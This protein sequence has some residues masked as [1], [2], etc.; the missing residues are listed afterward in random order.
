MGDLETYWSWNASQGCYVP[1]FAA[2]WSYN[3]SHATWSAYWWDAGATSWVDYTDHLTVTESSVVTETHKFKLEIADTSSASLYRVEFYDDREDATVF[4]NSCDLFFNS[5]ELG[6][7]PYNV[8][9]D[10][11]DMN[12][13][14]SGVSPPTVSMSFEYL[15][16]PA[17]ALKVYLDF[18]GTD[19]TVT[20]DPYY[21]IQNGNNSV[22]LGSNG[23]K[24]FCC[25]SCGNLHVVYNEIRDK[26]NVNYEVSYDGGKTWNLTYL[27]S[28]A[29]YDQ[30]YPKISV[31]SHGNI[32]VVFYGIDPLVHAT[33]TQIR[34][35]RYDATTKSWGA[36]TTITSDT[37]FGSYNPSI[38][39]DHDNI[40]HVVYYRSFKIYYI[41]FD[42]YYWST[43]LMLCGP[44]MSERPSIE[45][46]K[47]NFLNVVWAGYS[48]P[49]EPYYHIH[50]VYSSNHGSSFSSPTV[51]HLESTYVQD[52][53]VVAVDSLG[54]VHVLW[55]G[56]SAAYNA[57][58]NIRYSRTSDYGGHWKTITN[59]T[60]DAS[61]QQRYPSA[62]IDKDDKLCVLWEGKYAAYSA[63]F[64]LNYRISDDYG[65]TWGT[66]QYLTNSTSANQRYPIVLW[67]FSPYVYNMNVNI[68]DA[69]VAFVYLDD[70]NVN[71][72]YSSPDDTVPSAPWEH[73]VPRIDSAFT[74][75]ISISNDNIRVCLNSPE[76]CEVTDSKNVSHFY[77]WTDIH[78]VVD[79]GKEVESITISGYENRK[80]IID[81]IY[82][83]IDDG[84]QVTISGFVNNNWDG[85]YYIESM[86]YSKSFET[87]DNYEYTIKFEKAGVEV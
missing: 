81:I 70:L 37:S 80:G 63:Y 33:A 41:K 72:W 21:T 62:C 69:G 74:N 75:Q 77:F 31:D 40:V 9:L 24:S 38:T 2:L 55:H 60:T 59:I 84:L 10:I 34:Y 57:V 4:G 52:Y 58:E 73:F 12:N 53:P 1:N 23:G 51:I 45:C 83:M 36:V 19:S 29:L 46:D 20:F 48:S 61:Y 8:T 26:I 13:Y 30:S 11:S 39:I 47:N 27:T 14:F 85:T 5:H 76:S 18:Y 42:G 7:L 87:Q 44:Y 35:I 28:D 25:D 56:K 32:F 64:Q 54:Y 49:G 65:V 82:N 67:S 3:I 16:S 6:G 71:Y 22:A 68:P 78:S 17:N 66:A 86:S 50:Y 15:A 43:P 79:V